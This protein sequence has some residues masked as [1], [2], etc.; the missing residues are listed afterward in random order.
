MILVHGACHGSWCW[1]EL[2]PPL[3]NAGLT[4]T[5]VDLPLTS[6]ADDAH[7]VR[8]AVREAK[9]QG[10][11]VLLAAHSY[12]GVVITAAGHEAD[13]LMYCAATMPDSDES[14]SD[15][16]ERLFTPRLE[17]AMESMDDP[18]VF[19]L[20][21]EGATPAFY[22]RCADSTIHAVLP[23]LRPMHHRC[24]TA[25]VGRASWR[26]VPATYVVCTDDFAMAPSY[27]R[28]C[29]TILGDY[30]EIDTDHSLFY[31]APDALLSRMLAVA[32]RMRDRAQSI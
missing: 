22:N 4:V 24:M 23:R 10:H 14:A 27:Q 1:E 2:S 9:E 21:A 17:A 11:M 32:S 13:E 31:S 30:I 20:S 16:F 8:E 5:A 18:A 15:A 19:R 25:P 12:G 28:A 3:R 29:A 26:D 7:V 6:L